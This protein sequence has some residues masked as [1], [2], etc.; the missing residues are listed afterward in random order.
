MAGKT[1]LSA[2]VPDSQS[3]IEQAKAAKNTED[4]AAIPI[5]SIIGNFVLIKLYI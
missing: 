1:L 3:S 2:Y 5:A 4:Q